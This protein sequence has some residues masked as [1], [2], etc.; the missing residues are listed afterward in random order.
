MNIIK[1]A[2]S[3]F[4]CRT[5]V[6]RT[7]RLNQCCQAGRRC[8]CVPATVRRWYTARDMLDVVEAWGGEGRAFSRSAL[9]ISH[10]YLAPSTFPFV[11]G[12]KDEGHMAKSVTFNIIH[13]EVR[14][15]IAI[16]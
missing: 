6:H 2:L 16:Y 1:V 7:V 11:L 5:T 14:H 9:L 3:H 8:R 15:Q 13:H 12:V 10:Y 4:C